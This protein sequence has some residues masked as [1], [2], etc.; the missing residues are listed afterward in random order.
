MWVSGGFGCMFCNFT[1][2]PIIYVLVCVF[3]VKSRPV[4]R[5]HLFMVG[6]VLFVG[7]KSWRYDSVV[8]RGC[9]LES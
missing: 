7:G 4:G 6:V 1:K 3:S 9:L 2:V 8:F 5:G